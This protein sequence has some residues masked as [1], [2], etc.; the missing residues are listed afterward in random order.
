L[1]EPVSMR[2]GTGALHTL[3]H[4]FMG[5]GTVLDPSSLV[6]NLPLLLTRNTRGAEGGADWRPP[7]LHNEDKGHASK[8]SIISTGT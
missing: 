4:V 1:Q 7:L 3:P 8:V 6:S 5:W 2:G